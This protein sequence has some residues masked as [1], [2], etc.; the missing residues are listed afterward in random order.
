M[1]IKVKLLV[2]YIMKCYDAEFWGPQDCTNT[3]C[4]YYNDDPCPAAEGCP[5][6][7]GEPEGEV[8]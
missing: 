3:S 1:A 7:I 8:T 5:G 2:N 4:P 6:Y